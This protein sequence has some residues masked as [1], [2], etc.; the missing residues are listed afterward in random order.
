M[1][2]TYVDNFFI[3]FS[4][5]SQAVGWKSFDEV[6]PPL[7]GFGMNTNLVPYLPLGNIPSVRLAIL[8]RGHSI[9]ASAIFIH[10][11]NYF[12]LLSWDLQCNNTSIRFT[13]VLFADVPMKK[14]LAKSWK[15]RL[16]KNTFKVVNFCKDHFDVS[17]YFIYYLYILVFRNGIDRLRENY[18]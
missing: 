10:N 3:V 1:S 9:T 18:N 15:T 12:V 4:R 2:N 7:P 14:Y 5:N 16:C 17:I 6:Y 13:S 11:F 8:H